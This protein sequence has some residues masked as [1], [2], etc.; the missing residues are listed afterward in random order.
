MNKTF[1]L[2]TST[3]RICKNVY[4]GYIWTLIWEKITFQ[5]MLWVRGRQGGLLVLGSANVDE[6][7]RGYMTKY[8]CSSADINPIGGFS[9]SDLKKFLHLAKERQVIFLFHCFISYNIHVEWKLVLS[10]LKLYFKH[11]SIWLKLSCL[12]LIFTIT[13]LMMILCVCCLSIV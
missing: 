11:K 13:M 6:A 2:V 4:T 12:S 8:D 9:K 7:L 1:C 5:L 10:S 3:S